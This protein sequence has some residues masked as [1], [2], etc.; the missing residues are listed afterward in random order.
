DEQIAG[1]FER[2]GF[3]NPVAAKSAA[4]LREL[5]SGPGVTVTT[6][7][8]KFRELVTDRDDERKRAGRGAI[9]DLSPAPSV[10]GC[11]DE[12]HRTQY[13]V[14]AAN[15]RAALPNACFFAFSG[16]PIDR[17]DRSTL[18]T[19]GPYIDTYSIRQAVRD[20]A[21][22]PIFYE[23]RLPRVRVIGASI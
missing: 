14:F 13:G 16:T 9:D 5:L 19:F 20:H 3:P 4:D 21:T 17:K 23:S 6:T 2:C 10:C 8:Q 11:V 1:T 7:V 18:R 12:A 15:M 22:V